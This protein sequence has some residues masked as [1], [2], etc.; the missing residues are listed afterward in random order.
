MSG[1][2]LAFHHLGLLTGQPDI[3]RRRLQRLGYTCGAEVFDPLQDVD[4]CM[5]IGT[6]PE[7]AI[8]LVSP[9]PSNLGLSR[10]LRRRDDY[11]YHVCYSV[12]GF[13]EALEQL[14]SGGQERVV[15]IVE[16][17]SAV[18]FDGARVMFVSVPGIGLVELLERA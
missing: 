15:Q 4:L 6:P 16:P 10:L 17:K 8:E 13:P 18:L 12:S 11:I 2:V 1:P 14:S 9:R 7:P 3:A 5:C